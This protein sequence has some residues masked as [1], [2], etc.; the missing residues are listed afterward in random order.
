VHVDLS[1]QHVVDSAIQAGDVRHL[2]IRGTVVQVYPT[3]MTT[4]DAA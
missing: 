4:R 3:R 1:V 2:A